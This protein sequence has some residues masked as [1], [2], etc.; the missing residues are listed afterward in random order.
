VITAGRD[1]GMTGSDL[2]ILTSL[3]QSELAD[4]AAGALQD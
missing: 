4:L 3:S 1:A 2:A